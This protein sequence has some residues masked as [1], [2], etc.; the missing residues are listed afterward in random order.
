MLCDLHLHTTKSDGL[1]SPERLFEEIRRRDLQLFS[2]TDHDCLDAY[3]VP[4]DLRDRCIPGLEVDSHH[5]GHTVH[6]LAY[7]IEDK[8]SPLL[9]ALQAQREDRLRRMHGMVNRLNLLGFTIAMDDVV[10]QATGASS[11][12]RP[13]LARALVACGQVATVQEAF[14]RYI[15]DD[16][17]AY[18]A[19]ERLTS[20]R[21]IDLIHDSGGVAVVAHPMRLRDSRHLEELCQLGADGIE[22]VHPT[23]DAG[24]EA[25]F[26]NFALEHD[27][28]MTGGSDF[29]TPVSGREIGI[30][31]QENACRALLSKVNPSVGSV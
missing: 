9:R 23:A 22:V 27:L 28:L 31:L 14:D 8:P 5:G 11:L 15:A 2:I 29:H 4:E 19:L 1:W 6:I 12:G 16:R 20:A 13:H 21:V 10:A 30:A 26:R 3:P 7:G 24:A 17:D 18:V 25:A